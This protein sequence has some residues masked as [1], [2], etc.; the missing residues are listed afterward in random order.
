M[1][2]VLRNDQPYLDW[3]IN[4]PHLPL[5]HAWLYNL[6]YFRLFLFFWKL[7]VFPSTVFHWFGGRKFDN[8]QFE[9]TQKSFRIDGEKSK[10]KKKPKIIRK[11]ETRVTHVWPRDL[12]L[13]VSFLC[14][15]RSISDT[16]SLFGR[17]YSILYPRKNKQ[18]QNLFVPHLCFLGRKTNRNNSN[19][20]HS[21]L[22][23]FP[24]CTFKKMLIFSLILPF[25]VPVS[26]NFFRVFSFFLGITRIHPRVLTFS[27]VFYVSNYMF[28]E[29]NQSSV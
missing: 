6:H 17:T 16:Y 14:H 3:P 20:T 18:K 25:W 27:F 9:K 2:T 4:A 29:F 26:L 12:T 13:S 28:S 22:Q 10:E 5:C 7:T 21:E 24:F 8:K 1:L 19:S 23:P 11:K 15:I